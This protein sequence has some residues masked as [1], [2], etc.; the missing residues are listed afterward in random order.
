MNPTELKETLSRKLVVA[1]NQDISEGRMLPATC[2]ALGIALGRW[3]T[4]KDL[5]DL[6][7]LGKSLGEPEANRWLVS[8]LVSTGYYVS[9]DGEEVQRAA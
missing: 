2:M 1:I 5:D 4:L 9:S 3:L 6:E 8:T 7:L